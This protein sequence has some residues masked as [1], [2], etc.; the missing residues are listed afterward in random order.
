MPSTQK[1]T[2]V[3]QQIVGLII[4][5]NVIQN[6]DIV[7]WDVSSPYVMNTPRYPLSNILKAFWVDDWAQYI[8]EEATTFVPST[9]YGRHLTQHF[10]ESS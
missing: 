4:I 3:A 8:V 10:C 2:E 1:Q 7:Q 5:A 6:T 9:K